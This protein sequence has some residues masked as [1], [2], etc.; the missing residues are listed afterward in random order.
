MRSQVAA[1]RHADHH[2]ACGVAE[3]VVDEVVEE[4][5]G[6]QRVAHDRSGAPHLRIE[7]EGRARAVGG[8]GGN[9]GHSIGTDEWP[10]TRGPE[11]LGFEH[12]VA[13]LWTVE[14]DPTRRRRAA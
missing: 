5:P 1:E 12:P 3:R 11:S 4:P 8:S 2:P 14:A 6:E 9:V 7:E 10:S 13:G